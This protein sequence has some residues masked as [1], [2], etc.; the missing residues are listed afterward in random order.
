M[1]ACRRTLDLT[2]LHGR[3]AA[4]SQPRRSRGQ[5]RAGL[6]PGGE[7]ATTA[8]RAS[9][10]SRSPADLADDAAVEAAEVAGPRL[11]Q[12]HACGRRSMRACSRRRC[13]P[14]PPSVAPPRRRGKG[15]STSS[16]SRR[17]R[18]ARCMSAMAAARCSAT[19]WRPC[20]PSRASRRRANITSTTPAPRSTCSRARP[21][22]ATARRSARRSERSPR[23]STPATTS[24]RSAKRSPADM[25]TP[26][27]ISP[28]PIWL[29]PVRADVIEAMMGLIR[30][31]LA[32]LNIRHEVFFSERS[33]TRDEGH[34]SAVERDDRRV[35][36]SAASSTRAGCR[37]PR[38]S[39]PTIGR[40]ASR[41]CSAR[42]ISGT[43]STGRC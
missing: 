19:R 4:R 1:A 40:T 12:H 28:R 36:G 27:A 13:G 22:C 29:A 24:C 7:D 32:A 16:T 6:R 33:L 9:S 34:G 11:H 42:R 8:T 15:P 21:S 2:P 31:D 35:C 43:T 10:R 26:C 25:A 14:A 41:R 39:C 18:P 38:D 20:W 23:G 17:T 5:R 3:A 37:R 30:A